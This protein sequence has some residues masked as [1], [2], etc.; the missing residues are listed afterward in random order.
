M[1]DCTAA[2]AATATPDAEPPRSVRRGQ[3]FAKIE[4]VR[5]HCADF[6]FDEHVRNLTAGGHGGDATSAEP[7]TAEEEEEEEEAADAAAAA[8]E[9]GGETAADAWEAHY[10]THR[11]KF[12]PIKNYVLAAFPELRRDLLAHLEVASVDGDDAPPSP[13]SSLSLLEC[14][15]GAGSAVLPLLNL[16][17]ER[18]RGGRRTPEEEGGE[19]GEGE[20][21]LP[22]HR[23]VG[24]VS[25]RSFDISPT[26][27]AELTRHAVFAEA[28][29]RGVACEACVADLAEGGCDGDDDDEG[30]D[31]GLP[32][33]PGSVD[34]ALMLFVLS[35]LDPA[36]GAMQRGVRRVARQLRPGGVVLLRDY[37][38]YDQ[39]HVR[40]LDRQRGAEA[41][42]CEAGGVAGPPYP[43]VDHARCLDARRR[44]R[45]GDGTLSF[46]YT[47]EDVRALARG[48]GLEVVR[49]EYHCAEQVNRRTGAAVRK[50]FVN[51]VL[52]R[53]F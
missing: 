32:A 43:R 47:T 14:G 22:Q 25:Y 49:S 21:N 26:A 41:S 16:H 37:A 9:V 15:C 45:R 5:L 53:P 7:T 34:Y 38:V 48:A 35:A 3:R 1:P 18:L 8:A 2:D 30:D 23:L 50:V 44:F 20:E 12:Y 40:F 39:A 11:G 29:R 24:D 33:P 13:F 46:F 42:K 4:D 52:R 6:D 28:V 19:E 10:A 17:L 51:A 27:V 36:G 31:K